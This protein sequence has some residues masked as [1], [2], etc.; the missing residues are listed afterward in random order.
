MPIS[1]IDSKCCIKKPKRSRTCFIDYLGSF[2]LNGF[3]SLCADTHTHTHTHT[4]THT[5]THTNTHTNVCTKLISR[6]QVCAS[7][8]IVCFHDWLCHLATFLYQNYYKGGQVTNPS[9][10]ANHENNAINYCNYVC[11]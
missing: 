1:F 5:H 3:H 11:H 4:R 9:D 8:F 7:Q 2:H 10:K 6:N